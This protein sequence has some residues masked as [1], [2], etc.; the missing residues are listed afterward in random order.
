MS[1]YDE[2]LRRA[3]STFDVPATDP[4]FLKKWVPHWFA[5]AEEFK[6]EAE[7]E[8]LTETAASIQSIIDEQRRT[9]PCA[10]R[11]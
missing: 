10:A 7:A 4:T 11:S 9:V 5:I 1:L 2:I 3:D 6:A 8:G